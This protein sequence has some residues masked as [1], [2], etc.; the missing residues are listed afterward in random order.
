MAKPIVLRG[1]RI[2][3]HLPTEARLEAKPIMDL[4][5]QQF[6]NLGF[7]LEDY[8]EIIDEKW[9]NM[10][11]RGGASW[12][13]SGA[14]VGNEDDDEKRVRK[15]KFSP[16]PKSFSNELKSIRRAIYDKQYGILRKLCV[17]LEGGSARRNIYIMP[18]A[19][20]PQFTEELEA[21]N[22]RT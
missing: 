22:E 6:R 1:V 12:Q 10:Q 3:V 5:P 14:R 13:G 20:I 2:A 7:Q 17:V 15:I 8:H 4:A 21:Q 9:K 16:F 11:L 18:Y 19:N